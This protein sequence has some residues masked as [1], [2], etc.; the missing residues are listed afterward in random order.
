MKIAAPRARLKPLSVLVSIA[1]LTLG[2]LSTAHASPQ[3]DRLESLLA[4]T[5]EGGW[6]KANVGT[7][8][9]AWATGSTAVPLSSYRNPASIVSAWSSF[10]WDSTRGDLLLWGGGHANYAGNEMYVWDANSGD[11]SRGSLPSRIDSNFFVVDSA[12]PQSSHTYENNLYLPVNGVFLT[13]GGAA[14]QSGG[15]F[16]N[17]DGNN[18]TPSGPWVWDP[19]KADPN[20]VGGTTGSGWDP[21]TE[22]GQMWTDRYAQSPANTPA[23]FINAATAYRSENGKDVVYVSVDQ[24]S[25][26]FYSLYRYIVGDVKSGGMDTWEKIGVMANTAANGGSGTIDTKNNLFIRTAAVGGRYTSNLAVW[27]LNKANPSDPNSNLDIGIQLVDEAGNPFPMTSRFGIEYDK[28]NGQILLWDG[29]EQ[30]TV[31]TVT[32]Q[33]DANGKLLTTWVVK[34]LISTTFTQPDGN[35]STGVLGKWNYIEELDAFM[36]LNE[37]S[38]TTGDAEVWLYKPFSTTTTTPP[39]NGGT[40]DEPGMAALL[41]ASLGIL[42]VA[43][44]RRNTAA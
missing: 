13:F 1:T 37:F 41:L 30:G 35:F 15:S 38:N 40:V 29:S 14:F 26:G 9:E 7:F 33:Y 42:G 8:S 10:A 21:S 31:W 4:A 27:D 22:G 32:P 18:I 19:T 25:S 36:A 17:F 23:N 5:P 11:W 24:G 12:A 3:L 6:V 43:R 16:R 39:P 28:K 44:R 2:A 34:K 20:K